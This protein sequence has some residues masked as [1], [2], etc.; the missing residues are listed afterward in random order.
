V[1]GKQENTIKPHCP[2]FKQLSTILVNYISE[3]RFEIKGSAVFSGPGQ[4]CVK[5]FI[6]LVYKLRVSE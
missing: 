2:T 3:S 1:S 4:D 5:V 6:H